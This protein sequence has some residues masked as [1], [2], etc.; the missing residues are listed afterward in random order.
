[1]TVTEIRSASSGT[2]YFHWKRQFDKQRVSI[3][4]FRKAFFTQHTKCNLNLLELLNECGARTYLS[5]MYEVRSK[6]K[7]IVFFHQYPFCRNQ[8][9]VPDKGMHILPSPKYFW[10][11]A[12]ILSIV[13]KHLLVIGVFQFGNEKK[14]HKNKAC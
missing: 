9:E 1:M 12:F 10:N 14:V 3:S 2:R 4:R 5:S 11:A 6:D 7:I 13:R 8:N